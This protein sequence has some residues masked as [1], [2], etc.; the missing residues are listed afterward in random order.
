V[1]TRIVA[2]G[3]SLLATSGLPG[4]VTF[5][6]GVDLVSFGVTVTDKGGRF[7][8]DLQAA[9]FEV[10]EDGAK[11]AI[12][13]FSN[14]S[15]EEQAPPE[16]HL[17]V[18]FDQSG[19]M[20]EDLTLSQGAVIKFLN[21][22]QDAA[23][24]TL[25]DFTTEVRV[26]RYSQADFPRLVERIR[27]RTAEGYTALYDALGV[28]LDGA[29]FEEG[30]KV[31]V[32]YTDGADNASEL[33]FGDLLTLLRASDVT[34]YSIGF[35]EHQGGGTAR[36][37]HRSRL[38][39]IA[40]ITGGQAFFPTSMKDLDA[41]YDKVQSEIRAQYLIGYLSTNSR[42]DG[43]WRRVDIKV[44]RPGLKDIRVRTRAG[45]YARF[46]EKKAPRAAPV[47]HPR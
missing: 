4:Q 19:S 9:D 5:R 43:S 8:R 26:A 6:S 13:F 18:L 27:T 14:G 34:V 28:Y 38:Q 33:P 23:D 12:R 41:V 20:E 44:T 21:T 24:I 29:S 16:L 47:I 35:L 32:L 22:L 45:Y 37:D 25:V 15:A 3:L 36:F 39:Q 30:R 11:Q 40:E 31:L 2:L 17:G 10:T 1:K 42:T 7:I 46:I